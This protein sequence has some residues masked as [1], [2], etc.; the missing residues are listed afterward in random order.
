M[1]KRLSLKG[2]EKSSLMNTQNCAWGWVALPIQWTLT[3]CIVSKWSSSHFNQ[4]ELGM[5]VWCAYYS[6]MQPSLML[7]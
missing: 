4:G 5:R 6:G 1:E 2:S 7:S 3:A